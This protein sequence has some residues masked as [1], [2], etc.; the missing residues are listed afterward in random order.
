MNFTHACFILQTVALPVRME[1]L[2]M[3]PMIGSVHIFHIFTVAVAVGTQ[4]PTA[5]IVVRTYV[6][7]HMQELVH[8]MHTVCS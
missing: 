1:E 2:V 6:F 5:R 8:V 7:A 4:D 3:L